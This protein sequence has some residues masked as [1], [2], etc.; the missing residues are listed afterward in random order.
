MEQH[1]QRVL[2]PHLLLSPKQHGFRQW[3]STTTALILATQSI[4]SWL[5]RPSY[6]LVG[7]IFFDLKKAFD[8]VPHYRLLQILEV[9][10]KLPYLEGQSQF[11]VVAS[12]AS[13]T[14]P[15]FSGVPQG[16]VSAPTLFSA[17]IKGSVSQWN[18]VDRKLPLP[19]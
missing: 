19:G 6:R 2:R 18:A 17:F 9:R 1:V 11:T 3:H 5:N 12:G 7:G 16:S 8:Q 10:H 15:V 4:R 14:V 13:D